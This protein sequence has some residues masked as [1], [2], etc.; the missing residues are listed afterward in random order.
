MPVLV[1][2]V[3]T[4]I[5][6]ALGCFESPKH[7]WSFT[8]FQFPGHQDIQATVATVFGRSAALSVEWILRLLRISPIWVRT[9]LAV[10]RGDPGMATP[11]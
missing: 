6:K 3:V 1:M 5:F 4:G 11:T 8:S 10:A 2:S 7:C 9:L